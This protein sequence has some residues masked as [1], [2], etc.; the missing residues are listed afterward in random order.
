MSIELV[1]DSSIQ[2]LSVAIVDLSKVSKN[3]TSVYNLEKFSTAAE[4]NSTIN[5]AL[6]NASCK[7]EDIKSVLVSLG[8]GSFTGL[9]I[10]M[11]WV[12]GFI[13]GLGGEKKCSL[14]GVSSLTVLAERL[15]LTDTS[16]HN[17]ITIVL[18]S[19]VSSGFLVTAY[20][21]SK[22][23]PKLEAISLKAI[24]EDSSLFKETSLY[25]ESSW[26][27]MHNF[28]SD[29]NFAAQHISTVE[30]AE[31]ALDAMC[32]LSSQ[33]R[34]NLQSQSFEPLYLRASTAELNRKSN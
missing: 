5:E 22:Q 26:E 23:S 11:A 34:Q 27:R 17:S 16:K 1:V 3:K 28:L 25:C 15:A 30:L 8:P 18:S 21:D 29:N 31:L 7:K 33:Q 4:I 19:N 12:Q 2:G 13:Q 9:R 20:K 32:N 24:A 10:G 6:T 14:L